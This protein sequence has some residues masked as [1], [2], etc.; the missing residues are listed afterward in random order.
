MFNA[1][2]QPLALKLMEQ[3]LF[4]IATAAEISAIWGN[5]DRGIPGYADLLRTTTSTSHSNSWSNETS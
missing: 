3:T 5:D 1:Q 2:P 4:D